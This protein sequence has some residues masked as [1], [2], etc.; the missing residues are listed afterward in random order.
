[1]P[2]ESV[3]LLATTL[4]QAEIGEYQPPDFLPLGNFPINHSA[5][6]GEAVQVRL[7]HYE[8]YGFQADKKDPLI[9][10]P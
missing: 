5:R 1:M 9:N 10:L 4:Q 3:L 8:L 6:W 7:L 2:S